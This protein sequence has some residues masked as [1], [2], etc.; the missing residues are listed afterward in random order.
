M[1]TEHAWDCAA[2]QRRVPYCLHLPDA[3]PP[4]DGWPTLLLLHGRGRHHRSVVDAP[5]TG[6]LLAA[7]PYA[8]LCPNGG[9]GWYLD[10][11]GPGAP[12]AHRYQTMLRELLTLARTRHPLARVPAR[13]A[14]TGWSMGG[15]GAVRF[16]VDH[17]EAITAVSS[18]IGLLDF[19]NPALPAAD[20]Y[21]VPACFGRDPAAWPA[22]NCLVTA[23]RLRGKAF[24]LVAGRTAFDYRMNANFH[25]RLTALGLAHEYVELDGGHTWATVAAAF[26]RVFAFTRTVFGAASPGVPS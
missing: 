21:A 25:A 24:C 18:I 22:R 15:Y 14:V 11:D 13:T 3:A 6:P 9:D 1:I 10:L 20:N 4:P 16:A 2:L 19:P 23:E 26:P 12:P 8:V 5:D 7:Q 17:P